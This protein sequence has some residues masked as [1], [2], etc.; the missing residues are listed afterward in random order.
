MLILLE[1]L[2]RTGKTTLAN[3]IAERLQAPV[4]HKSQPANDW[5]LEY[6]A[7]LGGH[8]HGLDLVLDRWH[9]G[10]LVWPAVFGRDSIMTPLDFRYVDGVMTKL[11][12]VVV[13]GTGDFDTLWQDAVANDEPAV[14]VPN[15]R[16]KYR[17][18]QRRFRLI[19]GFS[20]MP[21]F[22]YDWRVTPIEEAVTTV[23]AMAHSAQRNAAFNEAGEFERLVEIEVHGI[24]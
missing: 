23:L 16:E 2:D 12:G 22:E 1:G 17:E 8:R 6:V 4:I 5:Y 18:A 14:Q 13:L 19:S 10:E 3:A 11:G 20:A 15:A 24:G 7:P 21:V 9:W